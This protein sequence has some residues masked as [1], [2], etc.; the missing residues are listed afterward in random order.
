MSKA[1]TSKAE[2]STCRGQI[3]VQSQHGAFSVCYIWEIQYHA[4]RARVMPHA[5]RTFAQGLRMDVCTP[6]ARRCA[7]FSAAHF[8]PHSLGPRRASINLKV[9]R[10]RQRVL[11]MNSMLKMATGSVPLYPKGLS[12]STSART[13][14]SARHRGKDTPSQDTQK[15]PLVIEPCKKSRT[16]PGHH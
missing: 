2:K 3:S 15:S 9:I 1:A 10:G 13:K 7:L 8:K 4:A 12:R 6:L 11:I 16:N 5:A 14:R